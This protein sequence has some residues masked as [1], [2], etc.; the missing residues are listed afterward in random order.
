MVVVMVVTMTVAAAVIAIDTAVEGEQAIVTVQLGTH[1]RPEAIGGQESNQQDRQPLEPSGKH[2]DC[3][4]SASRGGSI[5]HP[6]F[7]MVLVERSFS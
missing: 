1:E 7:D 6:Q 3:R 5:A 4:A 2:A